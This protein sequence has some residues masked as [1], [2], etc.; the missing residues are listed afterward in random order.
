[1]KYLVQVRF[2]GADQV[3]AQLSAEDQAKITAEF[4]SV[5]RLAGVLDGNQLETAAAAATVRVEDEKVMVSTGPPVA[6]GAEL[7]GYYIYDAPD[8]D[9]ATTFAS[10]IP[11]ARMGGTVEVRAVV[12]R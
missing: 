3:I 4:Q 6:S 9:S 7:S 11:V 12:E 5:R 10:K 1:M 2:N 8:L